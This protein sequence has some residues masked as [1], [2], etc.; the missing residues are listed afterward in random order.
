[1]AAAA[2]A[3]NY[4]DVK[5]LVPDKAASVSFLQQHGILHNPRICSN[6][7]NMTLDISGDRWRCRAAACRKEV[8]LRVGTWLEGSRLEF[9]KIVLFMYCWSHEYTSIKWSNHELDMGP[10]AVVDFNNYMREVC[11]ATLLANRPQIG[12]YGTTV[13]IDESLFSKRK[14]NRGRARYQQWVFGGICR[15]TSESFLYSVPDRSEATL[16]PII[17]DSIRP[18]TTIMSDCWASY[19]NIS[20]AGYQHLSVNH[21]LNFVDPTTGAHTQ[22]IECH[23]KNAKRRNK[24]HHGTH[25]HMLDSYLCEWMWRQRN[26]GA[27]C[28]FQKIMDDIAVHYPPQ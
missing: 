3:L 14:N 28:L 15:E 17:Q 24:K 21:S 1:M 19:N 18:G 4:G 13:E 12:G 9:R 11:A 6:Q 25:K 16:L 26:R 5:D 2:V 8:G 22:N 10:G 27:P 20:Q 7:H 23:W